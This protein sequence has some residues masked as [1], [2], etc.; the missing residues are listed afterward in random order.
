VTYG[1]DENG[2][3][4]M[5]EKEGKEIVNGWEKEGEKIWELNGDIAWGMAHRWRTI[6]L[7][8]RGS[9]IQNDWIVSRSE[10]NL[11]RF[12]EMGASKSVDGWA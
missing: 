10:R 4:K 8:N 12:S 6:R 1:K 11:N 2:E 3:I 9:H 7:F 5:K